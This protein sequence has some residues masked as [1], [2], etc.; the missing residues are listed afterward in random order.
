MTDPLRQSVPS[1]R[2]FPAEWF[3]AGGIRVVSTG[4]S[5]GDMAGTGPLTDRRRRAVLDRPWTVMRQVHGAR[6]ISVDQ[7][8]GAAGE[9]GDAAVTSQPGA[10]LAVLTAD[11]A[12]VAMASPEGVVGIAHAGWRGLRAGVL[13]ATVQSMRR[14][15]ATRIEAV[16]GPC[17]RPC[18]YTFGEDQLRAV[19]SRLGHQIRATDREG[20][21]SLD[22]PAGVRAA[23]HA[24][25]A[26][27]VGEAG[28]CTGCSDGLW[29]WRTGSTERRQATVAW[30]A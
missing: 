9:E 22:L 25:G 21:P 28:A 10:A 15:G 1:S 26:N 30:R 5:H 11:C 23:L 4:W 3:L 29:S 8:G 17:I 19:E 18:C 16:L 6:V 14:M 12:P 20:R 7:P 13:E 27:L 2:T 24:A